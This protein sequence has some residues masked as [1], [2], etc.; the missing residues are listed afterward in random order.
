[1]QL[2]K[3]V[4]KQHVVADRD[5][6]PS[7]ANGIPQSRYVRRNDRKP[8]SHRLENGLVP[9]L[10]E[11]GQDQHIGASVGVVAEVA[12]GQVS[13][14]MQ[15]SR[16]SGQDVGYGRVERACA[17]DGQLRPRRGR[18]KAAALAAVNGSFSA[19]SRE[20]TRIRNDSG[21]SGRPEPG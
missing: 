4:T 18:A 15:A 17:G 2:S 6:N 8:A 19:V 1:M 21:V 7:V 20:T 9:A 5:E 16:A 12:L 13:E 10:M 11:R 14:E 3:D